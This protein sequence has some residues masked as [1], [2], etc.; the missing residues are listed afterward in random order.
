MPPAEEEAAK[1]TYL[2]VSSRPREVKTLDRHHTAGRRPLDRPPRS[3]TSICEPHLSVPCAAPT[4]PNPGHATPGPPSPPGHPRL[5]LRP[6]TCLL[7]SPLLTGDPAPYCAMRARQADRMGASHPRPTLPPR[8]GRANT[9]P[10]CGARTQTLPTRQIRAGAWAPS[11]FPGDAGADP[12]L[13]R[14]GAASLLQLFKL[15]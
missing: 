4:A 14:P 2:S 10:R 5:G 13:S 11:A 3:L 9:P 1:H 7:G 15:Q 12:V 6:A 8:R